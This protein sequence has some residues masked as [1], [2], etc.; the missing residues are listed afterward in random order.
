MKQVLGGLEV[1]CFMRGQDIK[2][3]TPIVLMNWTNGEEARLFS[4]LGSASVY[5]NGSSVAQAHVSPS[6]DH[7]GLTMGGELAKTGYVG[8]TPNIFAEYSISAQFK[9]HVEKNNDLEE[10]RK[11]LG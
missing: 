6:N 7:S 8:S 3:R 11:P 10:A 2:I 4:P 9:I 1:L 5:A